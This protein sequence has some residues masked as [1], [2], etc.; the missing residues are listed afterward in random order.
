MS[1][2]SVFDRL[3][4]CAEIFSAVEDDDRYFGI[5]P[6]RLRRQLVESVQK[7][8]WTIPIFAFTDENILAVYTDKNVC[9]SLIVKVSPVAC[10]S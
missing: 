9:L 7:F 2:N 3:Q 1:R 5:L 10:P 6:S 8:L 4:N